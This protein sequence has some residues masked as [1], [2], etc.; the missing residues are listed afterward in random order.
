MLR[1]RHLLLLC[2]ALCCASCTAPQLI[3]EPTA[4]LSLPEADSSEHLLRYT[5]FTS[6]YNHTTLVP[7][8]VS[9]TLTAE[10]AHGTYAAT[11]SFSRDPQLR[12]RQASREDYSRSGWDKGHMAPRADMKWDPQAYYESYYFTNICPQAHAL[13][14]GA[15]NALEQHVRLLAER[16]GAVHVVCGPI[17]H[18]PTP[19]TIGAARVWVPDAFFKAL[20]LPRGGSY[21]AIAFVMPADMERGSFRQCA[22]TVDSL[23]ALLGRNLF[24]ALPDSTQQRIESRYRLSDFDLRR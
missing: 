5:G 24:A 9:Y 15:W 18:S 19:R 16:Y 2:A 12:G 22:L 11:A 20:L 17:F 10:Q 8:W 3:P 14:A 6:S 21:S 23:E 1:I 7:N 4:D 13:N